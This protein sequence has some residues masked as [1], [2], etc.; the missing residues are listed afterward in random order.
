MSDITKEIKKLDYNDYDEAKEIVRRFI[1][2]YLHG[3]IDEL[4]TFSFWNILA[5]DEFNGGLKNGN[6]FDGDRTRI[7]YAI[8]YLLY[9]DKIP[10]LTLGDPKDNKD[11]SGDTINT[12]RTLFGNRFQYVMKKNGE[13]IVEEKFK[14]SPE[15]IDLKNDFFRVYQRIGNFYLLPNTTIFYETAKTIREQ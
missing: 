5:D 1:D 2:K 11:Y 7:V 12:F 3:N 8:D 4:K 10:N 13:E 6:S 15:Q 14:F 9:H